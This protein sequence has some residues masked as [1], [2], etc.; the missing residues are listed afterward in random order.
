MSQLVRSLLFWLVLSS[1]I[2]YFWPVDSLGF[3]P[4]IPAAW[5]KS[6]L[7]WTL[8]AVA[9]F[10]LGTLVRPDE[11]RPL[12]ERPWWVGLGVATQVL[13]MPAIAWLVT[14]VIPMQEEIAAGVIL[15]GCVPGAMASNVL[16]STARGSVAYSVSLTTV[17]TLLS[18]LTVPIVLSVVAGAQTDHS[19]ASSSIR[20]SL[21][22]VLP[23]VV[24]FSISRAWGSFRAFSERWS[25]AVASFALLWIIAIVVAGNRDK[26]VNVGAVLAIALLVINVVGYAAGWFVG[27]LSKLP[28]RYRRALTLEVGMQNA[29]LGTALATLLYGSDTIATIPT[30]AYTF[31][32]MLTGTIL[33]VTW[34]RRGTPLDAARSDED[35]ASQ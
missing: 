12:R 10:C 8:I 1:S 9:M 25:S 34:Q 7:L 30:A 24:G 16:T 23:T 18:P 21:L 15:V 3:D 6:G 33:A 19:L 11:L 27:G 26:L 22:V 32:C 2:A 20:L 14:R 28:T 5:L 17:A 35:V 4:F 31:G 29:G 13:V